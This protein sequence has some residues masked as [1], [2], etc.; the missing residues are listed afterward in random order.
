MPP[1]DLRRPALAGVAL[2]VAL[3]AGC[4]SS[5]VNKGQINLISLQEEWQLGQQLERDIARQMPLVDDRAALAYVNAVGQRIVRQTELAQLPWEFHIV[6]NPEVNAFN[7]PGGHVYVNSGLITSTDDVAEFAAVLAHEISHGVSRH[8]T[9]QL[10]RAYGISAIGSVLLGQNPKVY[11][12]ILAQVLAQGSLARFSRS[13]E[14]EADRLGVHYMFG[15]GYEPN[16]MVDMFRGLL[17]QRRRQPSSV[18]QFFATHPL[19]EDRI[20]TVQQEIA[21]LPRRAGLT[22]TDPEYDRLQS[23][24]ARYGR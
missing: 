10:S 14:V 23:R 13:A 6:A 21:Q 4:A 8:G 17:E 1:T 7:I 24:V 5:G 2:C 16:G 12:Q 15:A 19:T 18:E 11:E 3:A 22:T 9:E 20:G